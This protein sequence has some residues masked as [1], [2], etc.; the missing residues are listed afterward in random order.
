[1]ALPLYKNTELIF[2]TIFPILQAV[3]LYK[4]PNSDNVFSVSTDQNNKSGI[5]VK[6]QFTLRRSSDYDSHFTN[7][8]INGTYNKTIEALR[9][10]V[11]TLE[12]ELG[13]KHDEEKM[14]ITVD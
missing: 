3:V 5:S 13:E 8:G 12:G 4:D 10:Q 7:T 1:M 9:E 14:E 6:Q 11:K 2:V